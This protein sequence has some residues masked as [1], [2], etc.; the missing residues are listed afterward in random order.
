MYDEEWF[1][2]VTFKKQKEFTDVSYNST[3]TSFG[4]L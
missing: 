3:F 4:I 2:L 1:I